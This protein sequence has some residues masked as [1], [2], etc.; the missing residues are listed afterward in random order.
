M[1][2]AFSRLVSGRSKAN[3]TFN[4]TTLVL[5]S[6]GL[7]LMVQAQ[8]PTPTQS[9]PATFADPAFQAT[10]Q[11][12][13]KPLADGT[14]KRGYFWGPQPGAVKMEQYAQGTGGARLVQY[15]DKSRMEINNPNGNKSDPF[16]VTNGL[17]TV[18]LITGYMQKGNSSRVLRWPAYTSGGRHQRGK[19]TNLRK[20]PRSNSSQGREEVQPGCQCRS[21]GQRHARLCAW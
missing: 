17:L 8:T 18:E 4:I 21:I 15:F 10:W 14:V 7:P 20:F 19:W 12:T 6:I 9:P 3:L 16:Y 2:R 5:L 11:R 1:T 13:D